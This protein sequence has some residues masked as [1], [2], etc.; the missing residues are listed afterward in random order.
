MQIMLL[1]IGRHLSDLSVIDRLPVNGQYRN[2]SG[3]GIG[4]EYFFRSHKPFLCNKLIFLFRFNDS[5]TA[6]R[7]HSGEDQLPGNS[8][9]QEIIRFSRPDD[10]VFDNKQI[11]M[12]GFCHHPVP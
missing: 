3:F 10:A 4:Q 12:R 11:G 6:G 9:Q 1:Q 5:R 2:D 8:F 7:S